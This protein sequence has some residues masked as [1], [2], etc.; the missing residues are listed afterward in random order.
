MLGRKG[1]WEREE[2]GMKSEVGRSYSVTS[3]TA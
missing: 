1:G 3:E 2:V